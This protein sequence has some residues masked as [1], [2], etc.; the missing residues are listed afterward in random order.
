M[1]CSRLCGQSCYVFHTIFVWYLESQE[2]WM[3]DN[4]LVVVGRVKQ[5][6]LVSLGC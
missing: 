2:R 6:I 3:F 4:V 1:L 5:G